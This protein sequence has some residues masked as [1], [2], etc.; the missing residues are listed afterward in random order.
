MG[1]GINLII[2]NFNSS[3]IESGSEPS[4]KALHHT[5]GHCSSIS[6]SVFQFIIFTIIFKVLFYVWKKSHIYLACDNIIQTYFTIPHFIFVGR[7]IFESRHLKCKKIIQ[8]S[9]TGRFNILKSYEDFIFLR[10]KHTGNLD[11][12][13]SCHEAICSK[14]HLHDLL[15]LMEPN[16]STK[17]GKLYLFQLQH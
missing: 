14:K 5:S 7:H 8:F 3:S 16:A 6:E 2:S 11:E 1:N 15:L 9:C 4:Y 10:Y 17:L 13:R 12:N